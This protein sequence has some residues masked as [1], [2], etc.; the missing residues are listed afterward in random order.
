MRINCGIKKMED[1]VQNNQNYFSVIGRV[2]NVKILT[3]R[4]GQKVCKFTLKNKRVYKRNGETKIYK[5]YLSCICFGAIVEG[6]S[7]DFVEGK[8]LHCSGELRTL[9]SN[10]EI[11]YT[12]LIVKE[13]QALA[14]PGKYDNGDLINE[15]I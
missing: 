5:N 9:F 2:K 14:D 6:K 3:D 15:E 11:L 1:F 4:E 8:Q 13:I 12:Q 7:L 10:E